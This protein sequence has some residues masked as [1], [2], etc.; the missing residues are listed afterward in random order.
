MLWIGTVSLMPIEGLTDA[1]K[2]FFVF[3]GIFPLINAGFDFLSYTLTLALMRF[4]FRQSRPWLYA[5][6]DVIC[7]AILFFLLGV[8]LVAVITV[9]NYLAGPQ[10][11]LFS[12]GTLL[13]ELKYKPE[14]HL[15]VFAMIFSTLIPTVLHLFLAALSL[16]SVVSFLRRPALWLLQAAPENPVAALGASFMISVIVFAT[17]AVACALIWAAWHYAGDGIER[18]LGF[19]IKILLSIAQGI[20][21]F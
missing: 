9:L 19:Y 2:G 8:T 3:L 17:V 6:I 4:G 10:A 13:A 16:T 15:W 1:G 14:K 11:E 12:L 21:S 20:G 7:A 18:Y 5:G